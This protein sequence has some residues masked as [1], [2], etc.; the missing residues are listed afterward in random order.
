MINVHVNTIASFFACTC[1]CTCICYGHYC[2]CTVQLLNH[3]FILP[4][5]YV[6]AIVIRAWA[7]DTYLCSYVQLS[8]VFEHLLILYS[9]LAARNP[10]ESVLEHLVFLGGMPPAPLRRAYKSTPH[11]MPTPTYTIMYK[12]L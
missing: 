10:P 5:N 3:G 1:T 8:C 9:L 11:R 6:L 7:A 4:P 2:L 12:T